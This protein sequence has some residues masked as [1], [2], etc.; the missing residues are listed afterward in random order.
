MPEPAA[1]SAPKLS[2]TTSCIG[3]IRPTDATIDPVFFALLH[4][5]SSGFN[6]EV[7]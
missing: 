4:L 6:F 5:H 7:N 3:T 2:G 1:Q